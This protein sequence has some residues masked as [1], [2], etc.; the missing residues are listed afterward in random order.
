MKKIGI[1]IVILCI[2][3]ISCVPDKEI[4]ERIINGTISAIPTVTNIPTYTYYPTYTQISNTEVIPTRKQ[5]PTPQV[6]ASGWYRFVYLEAGYSVDYPSD[7]TLDIS[8]NSDLDYGQAYIVFPSRISQSRHGMQII[9]EINKDNK[10]LIEIVDEKLIHIIYKK[11]EDVVAEMRTTHL[12]GHPAI[13]IEGNEY[14]I[15][16]IEAKSKYYLVKLGPYMMTWEPPS[17]ESVKLFYEIINTM[18][19]F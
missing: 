14:Q 12:A 6:L 8:P 11:P 18:V 1:S 10:S 19:I 4:I 5:S 15:A 3:V 9:V 17:K 2:F 16:F 7:A 13:I